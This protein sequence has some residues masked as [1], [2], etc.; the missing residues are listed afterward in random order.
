MLSDSTICRLVKWCLE[1]AELCKDAIGIADPSAQD[2]SIIKRAT[3]MVSDKYMC[4]S[5][6]PVSTL[7]FVVPFREFSNLKYSCELTVRLSQKSGHTWKILP[8]LRSWPSIRCST[9]AVAGQK[10]NLS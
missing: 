9:V 10:D 1:V 5:T 2:T 6:L 8:P 7:S 4:R 3:M